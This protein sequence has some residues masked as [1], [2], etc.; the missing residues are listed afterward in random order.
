MLYILL[1]GKPPFDGANDTEITEKVLI[2]SYHFDDPI[3]RSIS[4]DAKNLVKSMMTYDYNKRVS[5]RQA[6]ENKWFQNASSTQINADL[7]K[8]SLKNLMNFNAV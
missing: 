1:S 3:W 6:L 8:E 5:C 4:E 2:G 7:M